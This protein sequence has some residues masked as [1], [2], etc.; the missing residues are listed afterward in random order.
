MLSTSIPTPPRNIQ[1]HTFYNNE[2]ERGTPVSCHQN[3]KKKSFQKPKQTIHNNRNTK[4]KSV[5]IQKYYLQLQLFILKTFRTTSHGRHVKI[6]HT[7]T[8]MTTGSHCS[9]ESVNS[10]G[11]SSLHG[12]EVLYHVQSTKTSN[13]A[14]SQL[15][16]DFDPL[17]TKE[18]HPLCQFF[19][20]Q[21][22]PIKIQIL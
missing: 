8:A 13:V 20:N 3:L 10:R 17:S 21:D 4:T 9:R 2:H 22:N 11:S 7:M 14:E 5:I 15:P 12:H 1:H 16:Q 18:F 6:S 19:F